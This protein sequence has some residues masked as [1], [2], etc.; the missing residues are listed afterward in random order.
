MD[1]S[2]QNSGTMSAQDV[3]SSYGTPAAS[4][5]APAAPG[6]LPQPSTLS[7]DEVVSQYGKAAPAQP[8]ASTFTDKVKSYW[9][10]LEDGSNALWAGGVQG[11]NDVTKKPLTA[12]DNSLLGGSEG[13]GQYYKNQDAQYAANYTGNPT[14]SVGRFVGQ[15]VPTL[16]VLA[17]GGA[18]AK[19]GGTALASG[20]SDAAPTI[21]KGVQYL[22]NFLSGS[23]GAGKAGVAGLAERTASRAAAS[24][25]SGGAYNGLTGAPIAEGAA[26]GAA[27][28]PAGGAVGDAAKAAASKIAPLLDPETRA[29]V[30]KAEGLGIQLRGPQISDSSFVKYADSALHKLPAMGYDATDGAVQQQFNGAIAKQMGADATKITPQVMQDTRQRLSN[31]YE[32]IS[33]QLSI[34][35]DDDFLGT[36]A[37]IQNEAPDVIP[38]HDLGPINRQVDNILSG[39]KDGDVMPGDFVH[40][41]IKKGSS[42]EKLTN[43][44]NPQVSGVANDLRSAIND[45]MLKNAPPELAS[46]LQQANSQ[47]KAMKTIEPLVE[48]S[49]TGDMSPSL[50]MGAVRK[51]YGGM[52][53]NGGGDMGDLARIGQRFLK[54]PN[55][56]GTAQRNLIYHSLGALGGLG[57]L[58]TSPEVGISHLAAGAGLAGTVLGGRALKASMDSPTYYNALMGRAG[59]P[60]TNWLLKR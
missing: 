29:L 47:W 8:A 22:T 30:Q 27:L 17:A 12:I 49:T 58:A 59:A 25:A 55:D 53:Y 11:Y 42:L 15:Q 31:T 4:S 57:A 2:T 45:A 54:E 50:L 20:L 26:A 16:P 14:A 36:L 52:A 18:L 10:N 5:T 19:A 48:K 6:E 32:Q 43:S 41:L 44:A 51:S 39:F 21:S 28:G 34:K 23:A 56:S 7:A 13:L 3:L 33:P 9:K 35:G 24:G 40:G 60:V 46:Q 37:K 38:E 1:G